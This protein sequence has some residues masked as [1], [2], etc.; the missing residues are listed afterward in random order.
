MSGQYFP[1]SMRIAGLFPNF[2]KEEWDI[3]M[4][5]PRSSVVRDLAYQEWLLAQNHK[6]DYWRWHLSYLHGSGIIPLSKTNSLPQ[7]P[8]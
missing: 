8:Q 3:V 1:Q 6:S 7:V 2:T 4:S 5:I